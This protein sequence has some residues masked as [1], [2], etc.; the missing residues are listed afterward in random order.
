M[1]FL[2]SLIASFIGQLGLA[3][4]I[5][6]LSVKLS[7]PVLTCKRFKLFSTINI[8]ILILFI[9]Y[10][11]TF[12]YSI[13]I[14]IRASLW[15]YVY[16]ILV[17]LI[18]IYIIQNNYFNY[19]LLFIILSI[20]ISIPIISISVMGF[21]PIVQ[22]EGRFIGYAYRIMEEG[23][24]KPFKYPENSY[25][26]PYHSVPA[27]YAIM[28]LFTS[29]DVVPYIHILMVG[30]ESLLLF[31]FIYILSK[32]IFLGDKKIKFNDH[33]NLF[34]TILILSTPMTIIIGFKPF[35]LAELLALLSLIFILKGLW[36]EFNTADILLLIII[37][38]SGVLIHMTF[39]LLILPLLS[40]FMIFK[41]YRNKKLYTLFNII[42]LISISYWLVIL[43]LQY[44][45]YATE[46]LITSISSIF[47]Q[48]NVLSISPKPAW[49]TYT[50]P[51]V[52]VSWSFI[53]AVA[54]AFLIIK[55]FHKN[56]KHYSIFEQ[57]LIGL[58][59]SGILLL[60]LGFIMFYI[61]LPLYRYVYPSYIMM[62]LPVS[63]YL[64][65]LIN[66]RKVV[67]ILFII[68][69]IILSIFYAVQDPTVSPDLEKVLLLPNERSWEVS[70]II[71]KYLS[72]DT[73]YHFDPRILFGYEVFAL[74]DN[75]DQYLV[76]TTI[77]KGYKQNYILVINLDKNGL[78]W[79]ERWFGRNLVSHMKAND[80]SM[81]YNDLL[82]KAFYVSS[83]TK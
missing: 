23:Y 61:S 3:I 82:Y 30:V 25:Y 12:I 29:V 38:F 59:L 52:S 57:L 44:I 37:S 24:W 49:Y 26:Q 10:L 79:I 78:L 2:Q 7:K 56:N 17:T 71:T 69:L 62:I 47:N 66:I 1:S 9:L 32:R 19:S 34:S 6:I 36:Y 51:E 48:N 77:L 63:Y 65:K 58:S 16:I 83:W 35:I 8:T 68:S 53:P 72:L 80:L 18:I 21:I 46:D 64:T 55:L 11:L 41:E 73:L 67:P 43:F 70:K 81:V 4:F 22:D 28:S 13:I 50:K 60:S 31:L 42:L 15:L 75:P 14:G 74:K 54:L 39:S 5:Y 45:L 76:M 40:I 20:V 27:T 33:L